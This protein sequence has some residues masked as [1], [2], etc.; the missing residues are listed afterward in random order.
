MRDTL[1]TYIVNDL[2]NGQPVEDDED[3]LL[4]GLLDSLSVMRL[5]RF[6]EGHFERQIPAEDVT[7]DHFTSI[8]TLVA[9]LEGVSA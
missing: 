3:L 8:D 6:M 1:R 2:L 4:S 5:V 7:I 9:Y